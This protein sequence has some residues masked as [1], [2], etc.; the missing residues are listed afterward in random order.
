MRTTTIKTRPEPRNMFPSSVPRTPAEHEAASD[1]WARRG[2]LGRLVK[3][4]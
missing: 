1:R 2:F 4:G 3:S